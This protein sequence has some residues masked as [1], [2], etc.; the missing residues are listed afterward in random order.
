MSESLYALMRCRSYLEL[1]ISL[2]GEEAQHCMQKAIVLSFSA[3]DAL[4]NLIFVG[5]L[6]NSLKVSPGN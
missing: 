6:F 2:S 5:N 4:R 1:D 3:V